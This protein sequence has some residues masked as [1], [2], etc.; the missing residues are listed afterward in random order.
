MYGMEK[1]D[2]LGTWSANETVYDAGSMPQFIYLV[3]DGSAKITAPNGYYLGNVGQDELFGE[4]SFILG[5]KRSTTIIAGPKGLKAKIIPPSYLIN[6]LERDVFLN[7]LVRKL[8]KRLDS[9]NIE[10][11]DRSMKI[12]LAN[13]QLNALITQIDKFSGSIKKNHPDAEFLLAMLSN[14][15]TNV[16]KINRELKLFR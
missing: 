1:I 8:E 12:K 9:S 11:V 5:T 2:N 7:A 10:T 16:E 15:T 3:I 13:E 14:F 4:A 6:K